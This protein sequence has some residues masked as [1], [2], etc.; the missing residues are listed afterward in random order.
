LTRA[1]T[2]TLQ[3]PIHSDMRALVSPGVGESRH[4][5]AARRRGTVMVCRSRTATALRWRPVLQHRPVRSPE[6]RTAVQHLE[7][8]ATGPVHHPVVSAAHQEEVR[9]RR[10]TPIRPVKYVVRV[11][12]GLG[13]ITSREP[14]VAVPDDH[15]PSHRGWDDRGAPSHVQGLGASG[16]HDPHDRGVAGDPS[17]G[18]RRDR[19]RMVELR[20]AFLTREILDS[21][22]HAQV[23]SFSTDVRPSPATAGRSLRGRRHD[24]SRES[25]GRACLGNVPPSRARHRVP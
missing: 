11:A 9:C 23:R 15:G 19:T 2:G 13:T 5:E 3:R 17:R 25:G 20:R 8:E 6:H 18:T 4:D 16:H 12:P 14:A 21:D 24:A 7:R 1:R 10:L 22:G